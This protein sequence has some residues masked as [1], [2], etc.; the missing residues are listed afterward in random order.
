MLIWMRE[1]KREVAKWFVYPLI[2][3]FIA[4]Y[5]S[6]QLQDNRAV[7]DMTALWVNGERV[8]LGDYHMVTEEVDRALTDSVIQPEK[9]QTLIAVEEIVQRELARQLAQELNLE[10]DDDRVK[11]MINLSLTGG[12]GGAITAEQLSFAVRQMGYSSVEDYMRFVRRQMD[13]RLALSYVGGTAVPSKQDIERALQRQKEVRTVELLTFETETVRDQVKASTD[14]VKA[15]FDAHK[16]RYRFPKRMK[17]HYLEARPEAFIAEATPEETDKIRWFNSSREQFLVPAE[18]DVAVVHFSP[19]EFRDEVTFTEEDLLNFYEVEKAQYKEVEKIKFRFVS[20]PVTIPDASIE[21]EMQKTPDL[22]KSAGDAVAARHILLRVER[23]ASDADKEAVLKRVEEMR[24]RIKTE[25]DFIREAQAGSDDTTNKQDGGDL[26]FFERGRMVAEFEQAAFSIP[27][28]TVSQPVLTSFGYHL[29]WIYKQ[30]SAGDLISAREARPRVAQTLDATPLKD[31]A[32]AKLKTIREAAAAESS[33]AAATE[34]NDLPVQETEY[35]ARGDTPHPD[36]VL[37]RFPLYQAAAPLQ[38]GQISDVIELFNRFYVIEM[39]GKQEDRQK[40]FE[41]ARADV[42]KGYRARKAVDVARAKATEAAQAVRGGTL[43]FDAIPGQYG[44]P[45]FLTLAD[46]RDPA[47]TQL[48]KNQTVDREILT[49][50]FTATVGGVEGPFDTLQGPT[51]LNLIAEETEHLPEIEEVADQVDVAYREIVARDKASKAVWDV[52]VDLEKKH[53]DNLPK[54]AEAAGMELKTSEFFEPGGAIPGFAGNSI[55]NYAAAGLRVVGATST[56]L[57][58]PPDNP[59]NPQ[60]ASA[61]YLVQAATIE[62]TRLPLFD[63]VANEARRDLELERAAP[64][65]KASAEAVLTQVA[66]VLQAATAPLSASRSF[67]MGAFARE[68]G[69]A[70][71]GPLQVRLDPTVQGLPGERSGSSI[72]LTTFQLPLTAVSKVVPISE[73]VPEG[74][75]V[76]ERVLGYAILQVIDAQPQTSSVA[77]RGEAFRALAS[78]LQ[79]AVQTD[80]SERARERAKIEAN[81]LHFSEEFLDEL[82]KDLGKS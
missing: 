42:E 40:T 69:L 80:W 68:K 8:P 46:L 3:V 67:D 14:E 48:P 59:Q 4:L 15:Y 16:E 45:E 52:W 61:F 53:G 26:G 55:V 2:F 23:D 6:S 10:T 65:A 22:F 39:V 12:Q 32:R 79:S 70:L 44:L 19:R 18:R 72:A 37:D 24:A 9:S 30:R 47:Q 17:I 29:L 5:G 81:H 71:V 77:T 1:R 74:D 60:P 54:A 43:T 78:S 41:E 51:L 63:E 76:V 27:A 57:R 49:Q 33:L 64:I 75:T 35:F 62:S 31:A 66:E 56:V 7:N 73:F 11:Q 34:V 21:A 25:E 58:D 82:M 28:A 13:V 20:V 50:A 36:A 38:P